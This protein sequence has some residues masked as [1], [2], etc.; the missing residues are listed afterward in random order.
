[1]L[2]VTHMPSRTSQ[3]PAVSAK[4]L[5]VGRCH[6]TSHYPHPVSRGVRDLHHSLLFLPTLPAPYQALP[7][8]KLQRST[9]LYVSAMQRERSHLS[10]PPARKFGHCQ[11]LPAT[12]TNGKER[13]GG[14][15]LCKMI[16]PVKFP[17]INHLCCIGGGR[18]QLRSPSKGALL[19]TAGRVLPLLGTEKAGIF[20]P[21]G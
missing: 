18:S 15:V 8:T 21:A 10:M 14:G 19:A 3:C 2:Y 17:L 16:S 5:H 20:P 4:H 9:L 1:M 13:G 12:S 6:Y 7:G 11:Y